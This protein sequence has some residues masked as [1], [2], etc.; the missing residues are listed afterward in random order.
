[1]IIGYIL[2]VI[3]SLLM[4]LY[5]VEFLMR[6]RNNERIEMLEF[7][8][9][10]L[11]DIQEIRSMGVDNITKDTER[12]KAKIGA[13]EIYFDLESEEFSSI[14]GFLQDYHYK[15]RRVN[16][17]RLLYDHLNL[18]IKTINAQPVQYKL[19]KKEAS[20]K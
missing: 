3:S 11:E 7:R 19:V 16:K 2:T 13:L 9:K 1:M 15:D 20:K 14:N 6:K 4:I 12:L 8:V 18:D 10:G 17:L 5:V